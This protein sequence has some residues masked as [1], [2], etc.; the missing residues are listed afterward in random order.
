MLARGES[1]V[2]GTE[3]I[4]GEE[5]ELKYFWGEAAK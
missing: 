1:P 3:S 2:R 5:R 4:S